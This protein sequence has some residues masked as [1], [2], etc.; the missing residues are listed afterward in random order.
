[1]AKEEFKNKPAKINDRFLF[2]TVIVIAGILLLL[3]NIGIDFPSFLFS[4]PMILIVI[5]IFTGIR[6][7]FKT[8]GWWI[9]LA[10]GGFF[11]ISRELPYFGIGHLFWPILI[12]AIGLSVIL[13]KGCRKKS[14]DQNIETDF[15]NSNSSFTNDTTATDTTGT[16]KDDVIDAAAIFGSVKKNIYSKNFKGGEI[17]CVFG[18]SEINLM[19]ADFTG[20]AKLEIV[21]IFGGTTLFIPPHWQIRSEAAAI[22]GAIEDKRRVPAAVQTDKVLIIEGMVLFGGI[23]IKSI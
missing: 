1:M 2:G 19:H 15:T 17:V 20:V 16:H 8:N 13:G 14:T 21:N 23:D 6:D 12:V 5:G 3:R 9:L 18:G 7:N 4:W 22:F 10:I 11:L